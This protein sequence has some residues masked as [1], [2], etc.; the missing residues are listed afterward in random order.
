MLLMF[1]GYWS[2]RARINICFPISFQG[3]KRYKR[4]SN[5]ETGNRECKVSGRKRGR[6]SMTTIAVSLEKVAD[7]P[8]A[9]DCSVRI[10]VEV[11]PIAVVIVRL[12]NVQRSVFG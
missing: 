10:I 6:H 11:L 2:G 8:V 1:D 5:G 4:I 9:V 3:D 7:A 12:Q